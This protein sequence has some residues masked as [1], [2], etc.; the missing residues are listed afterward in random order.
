MHPFNGRSACPN[1]TD[2]ST[3]SWWNWGMKYM[4]KMKRP[5]GEFIHPFHPSACGFE[6]GK[7]SREGWGLRW[8]GVSFPAWV[9]WVVFHSKRLRSPACQT[10]SVKLIPLC[11]RLG[12]QQVKERGGGVFT[13]QSL[14]PSAK[15]LS[16]LTTRVQIQAVFLLRTFQGLCKTMLRCHFQNISASILPP[17][18]TS[19]GI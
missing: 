11:Q 4:I 1:S 8:R 10:S 3:I 19:G 17:N 2:Q 12:T 7:Q 15:D 14:S 13:A 9:F 6:V 18:L 16:A 5:L